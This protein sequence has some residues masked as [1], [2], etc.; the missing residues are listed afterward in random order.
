MATEAP[1]Q[2]TPEAGADEPQRDVAAARRDAARLGSQIGNGELDATL[3]EQGQQDALAWMLDPE[4]IPLTQDIDVNVGTPDNPRIFVWTI[5]PIDGE[6]IKRSRKAAETGGRG[7][8]NRARAAGEVPEVDP[9]EANA[10]ICVAGVISPNL[11]EAA[12]MKMSAA[13]AHDPNP[14]KDANAVALLKHR[15]RH[16][17]GLIDQIAVKILG[18]SGYDDDDIQPHSVGKL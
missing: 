10:R 12:A 7:R 17:P 5:G 14:D 6:T 11:R 8:S 3:T 16:K 15:L 13:G 4:E 1:E 9:Q 18:L 2:E